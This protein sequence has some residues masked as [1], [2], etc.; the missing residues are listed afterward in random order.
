M[1]AL[2]QN[3]APWRAEPPGT[4]VDRLDV[5]EA[6]FLELLSRVQKLERGEKPSRKFRRLTIR[7]PNADG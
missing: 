1:P 3:S 2:P 4:F 5:I 6:A 7:G